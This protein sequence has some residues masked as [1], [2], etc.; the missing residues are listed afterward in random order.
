MSDSTVAKTET[1]ALTPVQQV[2]SMLMSA[3]MQAQL[4]LALPRH[5]TPE[6]LA[7]IVLTQVRLNPK[8]AEC[9][10]TSFLGAVM[11]CAQLGLEPGVLGQAW[12]IPYKNKGTL[13]ATLVV[14]YRGLVALAWRSEQL[15]S[16]QAHVV[17]SSDTFVYERGLEPK[18]KHQPGDGDERE[19]EI[20]HAYAVLKTTTGG[21]LFEVMS[22]AQI[23]R[24]RNRSRASDSGPWVTDYAEMAKKTVLKRLFKLA[25]LSVELARGLQADDEAEIGSAQAFGSE[26]DVTPEQRAEER[27]KSLRGK[28]AGARRDDSP[29]DPEGTETE[30]S[31][32][33]ESSTSDH[34]EE[35]GEGGGAGGKVPPDA[36]GATS[37][38]SSSTE[39][40]T[41]DGKCAGCQRSRRLIELEKVPHGKDCPHGK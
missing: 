16:V 21:T 13:T 11:E 14:G 39:P 12:I 20:T 31:G 2:E 28:L 33:P 27:T 32:E 22:R 34:D 4:K 6:R 18:L 5:V 3:P 8:L 30:S 1:R 9:T 36:A 29:T 17:Y 40:W 25:P 10:R 23:N 19:D 35:A 15:A 24:I 7:R 26:I 38:A 37:P 41:A